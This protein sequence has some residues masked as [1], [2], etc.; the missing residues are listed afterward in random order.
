MHTAMVVPSPLTKNDLRADALRARREY[1]RALTDAARGELEQLLMRQ[2]MPRIGTAGAVAGYHPMTHEIDPSPLLDALAAAGRVV[3]LPWFADRDAPM[4]FRKA[5][6]VAPG[7]WGV[8]Q[9]DRDALAVRPKVVLVPLVTVDREGNRIGHGQGHYDRA[10]ARL[11]EGGPVRMIG[12][13]WDVQV[14][15]DMIPAD[16]WDVPLDAIATPRRWIERTPA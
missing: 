5:P 3:A 6:A 8:P 1:A 4:M 2:V 11:R 15:D 9:P 7:P 13:A 16:P 12:I 10:L 14:L